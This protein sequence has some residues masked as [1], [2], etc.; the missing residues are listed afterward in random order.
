MS[1][2]GWAYLLCGAA[3]T[4]LGAGAAVQAVILEARHVVAW[5]VSGGLAT[6]AMPAGLA[7]TMC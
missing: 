5:V 2:L 1:A 6:L 4:V 3:G 7:L